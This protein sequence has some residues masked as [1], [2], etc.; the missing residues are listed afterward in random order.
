MDS[1]RWLS[2]VELVVLTL[3]VACSALFYLRT[4]SGEPISAS[5][6]WGGLGGG[7]GGWR[8]TTALVSMVAALFLWTL[9][10]AIAVYSF[11]VEHAD[12]ATRLANEREDAKVLRNQRR[13]DAKTALDE[14]HRSEDKA[15]REAE[16]ANPEKDAQKAAE[17]KATA[18]ASGAAP[19]VSSKAASH[20][21][22]AL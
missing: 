13:D 10:G 7:T 14:K 20:P 15:E 9:A 11:H 16:R 18:A 17:K 8:V 12:A 4:R 3:A 5:A 1:N 22:P 2:M 21:A 19:S 6:H